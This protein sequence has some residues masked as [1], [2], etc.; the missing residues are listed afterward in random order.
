MQ[1]FTEHPRSVGETYFQH[2][3]SAATFSGRMFT[4]ALCCLLHAIFPFL[5]ERTASGIIAELYD[6]M[7]ANRVRGCTSPNN[8]SV[9]GTDERK[10]VTTGVSTEQSHQGSH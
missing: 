7:V 6:R 4:G 3:T 8:I 2:M 10:R 1:Q 5:F 9:Y